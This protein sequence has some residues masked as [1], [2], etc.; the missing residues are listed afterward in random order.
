M[1]AN[2]WIESHFAFQNYNSLQNQFETK[3][4]LKENYPYSTY[5]AHLPTLQ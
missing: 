3:S 2:A 5:N 1:N 4:N